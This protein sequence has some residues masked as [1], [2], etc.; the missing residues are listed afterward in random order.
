MQSP[1]WE[2][3]LIFTFGIIVIIYPINNLSN[4]MID[5]VMNHYLESG[6]Y[7]EQ[8]LKEKLD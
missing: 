8:E 5:G 4:E 6:L 2:E 1:Q 3:F 7:N